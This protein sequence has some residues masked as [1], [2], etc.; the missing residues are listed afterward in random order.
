MKFALVSFGLPP[1]QSSKSLVRITCSRTSPDQYCLITQ[2]ELPPLR[3]S[4]KRFI[5]PARQYHYINPDYQI[6]RG[7]SAFASAAHSKGILNI[8]L[9][10][11]IHQLRTIIRQ[12]KCEAVV[13]CT[14]TFSTRGISGEQV[15]WNP[16]HPLRV[17]PLLPSV[18]VSSPA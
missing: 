17:R 8:L 11:R 16:I 6:I 10:M 14:G 7:C 15:S 9:K 13:A 18:D 5:P 1:S 3:Q 4:G 12:E 2:K